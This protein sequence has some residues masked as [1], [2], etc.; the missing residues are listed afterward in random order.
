MSQEPSSAIHPFADGNGRTARPLTCLG[1]IQTGY[2]PVQLGDTERLA[3]YS[4]LEATDKGNPHAF[5][6]YIAKQC[7]RTIERY[8]EALQQ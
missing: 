1:L 8:L 2:P 6:A 7:A 4:A 5:Q 3:Y